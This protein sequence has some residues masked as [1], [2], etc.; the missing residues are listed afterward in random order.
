MSGNYRNNRR[1]IRRISVT[2]CQAIRWDKGEEV[3]F[4]GRGFPGKE[5]WQMLSHV[6][7]RQCEQ[8]AASARTAA[9]SGRSLFLRRGAGNGLRFNSLLM[10]IL[11][12]SNTAAG[13]FL[14]DFSRAWLKGVAHV[15]LRK[16]LRFNGLVPFFLP[17]AA[18]MSRTPLQRTAV[19]PAVPGALTRNR[20]CNQLRLHGKRCQR[21][22][23]NQ[24][25]NYCQEQRSYVAMKCTHTDPQEVCGKYSASLL[26][27]AYVFFRRT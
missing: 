5:I 24:Q 15:T 12:V 8:L 23:N 3:L 13:S 1:R 10:S 26:M 6:T 21:T 22:G 4:R 7:T 27:V 18:G 19:N 11:N 14:W 16:V 20:V 9:D 17:A 2:G 25:V